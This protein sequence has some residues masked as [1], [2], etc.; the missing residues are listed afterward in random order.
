[1]TI[2]SG[3]H[4]QIRPKIRPKSENFTEALS[5]CRAGTLCKERRR[6]AHPRAFVALMFRAVAVRIAESIMARHEVGGEQSAQT[7]PGLLRATINVKNNVMKATGSVRTGL[8]GLKLHV[9]DKDRG[10][11]Q[12]YTSNSNWFWE[13]RFQCSG[14]SHV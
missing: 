12:F 7:S 3:M 10:P 5:V 8:S 14:Y 4:V 13:R 6:A 2:T 9:H 11:R 1:M